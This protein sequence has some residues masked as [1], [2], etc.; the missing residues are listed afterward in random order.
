[1]DEIRFVDITLRD[2]AYGMERNGKI[3]KG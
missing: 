3:A 1:M 2:P